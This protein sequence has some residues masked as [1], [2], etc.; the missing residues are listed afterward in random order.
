[1]AENQRAIAPA[2][3]RRSS[4]LP[5]LQE[6]G[7]IGVILI[8]G[9]ILTFGGGD[10]QTRDGRTVNNFLRVDNII[11]N[12][13]TPM[14]WIAIM[15]VG[16]TVVIVAG[17][18]DLSVGS[19]MA[20]AAL[21]TAAVLQRMPEDASGWLVIPAALAVAMG[22]GALCGL[23]NGALVVALRIHPFIITLGTL[24]IYRGIALVAVPMKT[25]PALD[26]RLPVAFTDGFI[27]H[28][29]YFG[30]T[31][32]YFVQPAPMVIMLLFIMA[33]WVY[34]Q[35]TVPG[36]RI[37]AVGGNEEAARFSGIPVARVKLG[38]YIL[39]GVAAGL[40]G[41]VTVGYHG[42]ANTNTAAGYELTV[43]AAAVVGGASLTGGVGTALGALLGALIIQMIENGIF[44]L[45]EVNFGIFK[46]GLSKEYAKI[47]NGLA[48]VVAVAIDRFGET[49]SARR[50]RQGQMRLQQSHRETT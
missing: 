25:L 24:Y 44:V 27:A 30:E 14:S 20:C 1:M 23:V 2:L 50:L 8:M 37:Y 40:A 3:A 29:T 18:I 17:G 31:G 46:L 9:A 26:H 15:A 10:I 45:R 16:A 43:I 33:V 12:V 34:L 39:A 4:A 5:R 36:R 7:L 48:I 11:P 49:L 35:Y 13:A 32:S 21:A 6:A 47:I 42:S 41:M 22:I 19:V 38:V 28:K